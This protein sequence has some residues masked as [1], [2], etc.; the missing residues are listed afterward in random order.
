MKPDLFPQIYQELRGLAAAKPATEQ[1][2]QTLDATGLVHEALL[3]PWEFSPRP[4]LFNG[5]SR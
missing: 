2:G 3:A 5:R 1:P 4:A